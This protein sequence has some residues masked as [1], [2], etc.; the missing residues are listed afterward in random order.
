MKKIKSYTEFNEEASIKGAVAG[1]GL[2]AGAAL[3]GSYLHDKS[4]NT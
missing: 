3:G 4:I 2:L 1:I